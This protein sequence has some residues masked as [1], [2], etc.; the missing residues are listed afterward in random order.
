M[1]DRLTIKFE[2]KT[3]KGYQPTKSISTQP[4]NKGSN[5]QPAKKTI[6]L[7]LCSVV[8]RDEIIFL[9]SLL[10]TTSLRR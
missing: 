6:I 10:Q 4:P 2:L 8:I 7:S 3:Q 9:W 1:E 5:V